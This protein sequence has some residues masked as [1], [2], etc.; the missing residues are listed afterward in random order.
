M[1]VGITTGTLTEGPEELTGVT[2]AVGVAGLPVGAAALDSGAG[3]LVCGWVGI[4]R[5]MSGGSADSG[6]RFEGKL[7]KSDAGMPPTRGSMSSG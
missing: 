3:A 5:E 6:G 7:L 2:V 4:G 1:G